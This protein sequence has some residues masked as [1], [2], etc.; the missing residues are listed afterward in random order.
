MSCHATAVPHANDNWVFTPHSMLQTSYTLPALPKGCLWPTRGSGLSRHQPRA[1]P[2]LSPTMASVQTPPPCATPQQ[3][4]KSKPISCGSPFKCC[5]NYKC[6]LLKRVFYTNSYIVYT[7]RACSYTQML[8]KLPMSSS[9]YLIEAG[10]S[11]EK[12]NIPSNQ[13]DKYSGFASLY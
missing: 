10:R 1:S 8:T 4:K 2:Q 11:N 12:L 6:T 13:L 9:S 7:G 3:A 5:A